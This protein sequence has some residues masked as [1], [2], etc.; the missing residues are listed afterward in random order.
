MKLTKA[1]K[2]EIQL[3]QRE[4]KIKP[5]YQPIYQLPFK[6]CSLCT[7]VHGMYTQIGANSVMM[8]LCMNCKTDMEK[9]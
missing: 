8:I 6:P 1:Q 9:F 4:D 2:R 3:K 5:I 7:S